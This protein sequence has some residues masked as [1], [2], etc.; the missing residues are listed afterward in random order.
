IQDVLRTGLKALLGDRAQPLPVQERVRAGFLLGGIGDSRFPVGLDDCRNKLQQRNEQFGQST[1]YW[2]YVRPGIYRIGGWEENEASADITLPPFW[3]AQFP[4]TIAQYAPFVED[5]YSDAAKHYWTSNGWQWKQDRQ[6]AEPLFWGDEGYS[7]ANQPLI[8]VTCYE[9]M[10]YAAWLSE[11][12]HEVLPA[13]YAIRLPT[14]AEWE[15]A[16][17]YDT[18]MQ[19]RLYPWGDE[20]PTTEYAIYDAAGFN[21]P[22]PVG[23]CVAGRAVCGALDLAGNVWEWTVSNAD[24]YPEKSQVQMGDVPS[25]EFIVPSRG[26]AYFQS[27]TGVR[28]GAR[29]RNRPNNDLGNDGF[30]VVVA[31]RSRTNVLNTAS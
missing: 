20:E 18:A 15:A 22:V 2:C 17:A 13:D 5:G 7:A 23:C 19:R 26:G 6:R 14:E 3:I 12:L 31:P 29:L 24:H 28:C 9:A 21:N 11:Q 25:G 4:I 10:A 27:S 30:R 1:G 16:A 8:G